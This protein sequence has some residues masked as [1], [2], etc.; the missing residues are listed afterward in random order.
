MADRAVVFIDGN[1]WFHGLCDAGVADRAQLDY[2]KISEKLLGPRQWIET[3]YY[4]G[5]VNQK[6]N[7]SLYAQQRSFLARLTSTDSRISVHFGR[8]E[9]RSSSNEAANELGD[10][11]A[12]ARGRIAPEVFS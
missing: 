11:L 1:N 12:G 3:R 5:Q 7:A 4:I 10:Y 9:P 8:I 6:H 2:R